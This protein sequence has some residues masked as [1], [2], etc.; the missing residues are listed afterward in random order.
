[1]RCRVDSFVAA[2][3]TLLVVS[4]D[5]PSIAMHDQ[6]AV[7]L[8]RIKRFVRVAD[9]DALRSQTTHSVVILLAR[10]L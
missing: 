6:V 4:I 3:L 2:G 1:M 8:V 9:L 7:R 10:L 5:A